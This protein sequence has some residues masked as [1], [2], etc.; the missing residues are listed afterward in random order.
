MSRFLMLRRLRAFV[1]LIVVAAGATGAVA[2][3]G[4]GDLTVTL[5]FAEAKNLYA[6]DAVQVLGV[7]V[8]EVTEVSPE[9][10]RVR[11]EIRLDGDQPVP[12]DARAAIVAPSMVSV[13][14]VAL[15]PAYDGGPTLGDGAVIPEAR[16]AVPVEWD[17]MKAQIVDLSRALGGEHGTTGPLGRLLRTSAANL[18]GRGDDLAGTLRLL[19]GAMQTVS[20]GSDDLFG[21]VSNLHVFVQALAASDAQVR[22]F[23]TRLA[24]VA[25]ILAGDGTELRDALTRLAGAFVDVR[26]FVRDHRAD[27]A[28]S[29]RE[30]GPVMR[31]LA[32]NRQ[33]LADV[34]QVAPG[35]LSNF[36][37][38]YDP[39]VPAF[40]GAIATA[41]GG[42][43]AT[44]LCSMVYSA[45]GTPEDCRGALAPI[46]DQ[47][48]LEPP[49]AG[50][51]P[52]QRNG[53]RSDVPSG[54]DR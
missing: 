28:A 48:G 54:G 23:N 16:T 47:I 42:D 4:A 19:S 44:F 14:H 20:E 11:V 1:A 35:A 32:R 41:Q 8:G 51:G 40:T 46:A 27:I 52:I 12:A 39:V 21:T 2:V 33:E 29:V 43:V 37:N 34:L 53:D 10:D 5:Y 25:A 24:D 9:P 45:G 50:A 13:R 22:R 36:Y 15:A 30:L 49:P 7:E 6:G 3:R 18:S 38:I 17:D 31:T 26:G